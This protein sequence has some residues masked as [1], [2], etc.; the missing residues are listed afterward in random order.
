ME[1]YNFTMILRL[2]PVACPKQKKLLRDLASRNALGKKKP[3]QGA[4]FL[5]MKQL[6]IPAGKLILI[7]CVCGDIESHATL[8][9]RRDLLKIN[10]CCAI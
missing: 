7:I 1:P 3:L 9:H 5:A 2:E 4:W 8:E 10:V 6:Y